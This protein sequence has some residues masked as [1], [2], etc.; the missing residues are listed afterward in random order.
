[1][2]CNRFCTLPRDASVSI[3]MAAATFNHVTFIFFIFFQVMINSGVLDVALAVCSRQ[4]D[5]ALDTDEY[6]DTPKMMLQ[7]PV[8]SIEW[9]VLGHATRELYNTKAK[10]T[11][12][13]GGGGGG[14]GEDRPIFRKW[15]ESDCLLPDK[16]PVPLDAFLAVTKVKEEQ[17]NTRVSLFFFSDFLF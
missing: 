16:V 9:E 2:H 11:K 10:V 3:H 12:V 8:T 13:G 1:L 5:P 6:L 17:K 14:G 15:K 7:D 4:S